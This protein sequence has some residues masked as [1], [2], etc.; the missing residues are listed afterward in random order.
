[1]HATAGPYRDNE[2][3]GNAASILQGGSEVTPLSQRLEAAA[4]G[5]VE[6]A[7]ARAQDPARAHAVHESDCVRVDGQRDHTVQNAGYRQAELEAAAAAIG[8]LH[9]HALALYVCNAALTVH[10]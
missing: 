10:A 2:G 9:S 8:R 3:G 1:M 6:L 7:H 5:I 4:C